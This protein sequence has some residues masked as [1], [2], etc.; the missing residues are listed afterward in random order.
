MG[1]G[2]RCLR[3]CGVV[4]LLLCSLGVPYFFESQPIVQRASTHMVN[5]SI[6]AWCSRMKRGVLYETARREGYN[7][8]VL[9]QHLDDL[10]RVCVRG[11]SRCLWQCSW[12][13]F[14]G[15][16]PGWV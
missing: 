4:S 7:V 9:A 12:P 3:C 15:R 11:G 1:T 2:T 10:V 6:C 13:L 5:Q 8:L 14:S 16:V